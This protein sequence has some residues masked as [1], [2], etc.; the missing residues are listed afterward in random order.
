MS[1][2]KGVSPA[3]PGPNPRP[4]SPESPKPRA[5]E[6]PATLSQLASIWQRAMDRA[7]LTL[8]DLRD[9]E[10]EHVKAA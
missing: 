8:A 5:M 2:D 3:R 6:D 7:G 1:E 4:S 10:E 9:P